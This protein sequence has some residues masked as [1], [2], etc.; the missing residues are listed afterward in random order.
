M[1]LLRLK[2]LFQYVSI[3]R[4]YP[5]QNGNYLWIAIF[6]MKILV[7][8]VV[9]LLGLHNVKSKLFVELDG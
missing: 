4:L 5:L 2:K 1:I 3:S 7:Y 9:L 6:E 8:L